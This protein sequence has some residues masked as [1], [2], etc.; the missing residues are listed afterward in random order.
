MR[1]SSNPRFKLYGTVDSSGN[2]IIA[3]NIIV[4]IDLGG[5]SQKPLLNFHNGILI[6]NCTSIVNWLYTYWWQSISN[7]IFE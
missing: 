3:E 2:D 6:K 1:F 5:L 7:L 4:H